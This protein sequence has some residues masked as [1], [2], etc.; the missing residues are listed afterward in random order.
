VTMVRGNRIRSTYQRKILDWLADG[1]GTVTEVSRELRI[2]I[3]HVSSALRK[4]RESGDVVRDDTKKRGSKYR[5][6]S[7]GIGR[8]ESDSL[9][10]LLDL[11]TWP[12]PPNAAGIVLARDG[13]MLLLGY[14]S[15]PLGPLL[16]LPSQPMD[17]DL[18]TLDSS[19]GNQGESESW[20][21]AV[22]RNQSTVWWDLETMRKSNPP[23]EASPMTLSAW[24]ERP[25]LMG[26]VRA[27]LIGKY[28]S[29]PLSVGSWFRQLQP[30]YW[31]KLPE[32][33]TDGDITIG[34][35]GNTGPLVKPRGG[36]H[37][38]L[39]KRSD[40]SLLLNFLAPNSLTIADSDL[41]SKSKIPLPKSILRFWLQSIHPRLNK[42][43]IQAKYERLLTDVENFSSNALTRKL[44]NDFPG[45]NWTD[46]HSGILD[47]SSVSKRGAEAI[48]S[49]AM[50][51]SDVTINLDWRWGQSTELIS[52]FSDDNR[53]G[54]LIEESGSSNLSFILSASS[55][56]GKYS[57]EM[58]GRLHLPISV[59][60][61]SVVPKDWALPKNP[62]D[63]VRGNSSRVSDADDE[64]DAM[65]KAC[66]LV[67]GDD[68]WA[69]RHEG[70]YP[71]AAWIATTKESHASRWRRIGQRI[72]PVWAKLADLN[73]FDDSDLSDLALFDD[74]AMD[75]LIDRVRE[76]PMKVISSEI[77]NSAVA[78]A[79]LLSNAWI[80]EEID[81]IDRWLENPLR[82]SEV[83]RVNWDLEG[84]DRLV[85]ACPH[86]KMLFENQNITD[87]ISMLAIMEDVHYSLWENNS[88]DWLLVCL[89][90]TTGRA[91]MASL[92]I[93]WPIILQNKNLKS[94][95]L[96][97][98]HHMPE[99][100]GR[101]S[102]LDVIE[103][104]ESAEANRPPKMGL[105]HPMA[106]WLFHENIPLPPLENSH[107][108]EIHI[109]LHRRFQQ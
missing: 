52:R 44:L 28:D 79:I 60:T 92:E 45:R 70:K 30:G 55:E 74:Y 90:S 23:E 102:L 59:N 86:H 47:T 62:Q 100:E 84:I 29:W 14:V 27:K 64:Y 96:K 80:R 10:R 89:S 11:V 73:S 9:S 71:L 66:E 99:G 94:E 72:D 15:N 61:N 7:T 33:L 25:K 75:I 91:A 65:W 5:L 93:P 97:M 87:R 1:G 76:N 41:L 16:G 78:T 53:C 34:R 38:R 95:E 49:Y 104:L 85:S 12:P 26:I 2:R 42:K 109:A 31:P 48:L 4:L 103:G 107:N 67:D 106:G 105:T 35:A 13:P 46:S 50:E 36:I 21:W 19:N 82:V 68:V 81:V 18:G 88:V 39:G 56:L 69:D 58:P 77:K 63:V 17:G 24:M 22:Q 8:L 3:P 43:S 37:A 101:L 32:I 51:T 40:R 57:L 54:L 6:T 83:M 98:V 20:V 108:K